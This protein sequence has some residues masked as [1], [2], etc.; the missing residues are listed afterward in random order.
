MEKVRRYYII[1][2]HGFSGSQIINRITV[3][4]CSQTQCFASGLV[5]AEE[6]IYGQT[7]QLLAGR[8][9]TYILRN[10]TMD[11]SNTDLVVLSACETALGD[12]EDMK[13]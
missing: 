12:L 2:T 8:W 6:M 5:L 13:E 1:A 9:H 11:L 3:L 4:L 10:C 7:K